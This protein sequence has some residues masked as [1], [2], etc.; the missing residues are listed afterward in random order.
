MGYEMRAKEMDPEDGLHDRLHSTMSSN[1]GEHTKFA[2]PQTGIETAHV[3]VDIAINQQPK[4]S[5]SKVS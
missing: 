2:M 1:L 4:T 5:T 3:A